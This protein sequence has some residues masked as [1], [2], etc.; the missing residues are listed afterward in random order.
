MTAFGQE[1]GLPTEPGGQ[2]ISPFIF[3]NTE[4]QLESNV[5]DNVSEFAGQPQG[6]QDLRTE[7]LTKLQAILA[8]YAPGAGNLLTSASITG[9]PS[10]GTTVEDYI[11]N[12]PDQF[13]G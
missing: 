10:G 4:Q 1:T 5:S 8:I 3:N 6:I 11:A 7:I 9:I 2:T 12:N 13:I